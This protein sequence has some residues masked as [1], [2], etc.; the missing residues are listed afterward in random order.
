MKKATLSLV[1][2]CLALPAFCTIWVVTSPDFNFSPM[3][4]T[5][6]E[7][8]TVMFNINN[9]HNVVEVSETTWN[10]N[11]NTPLS[12]GFSLP[13]GGGMLLPED[14]TPGE[15][16]YVCQ[17]HADMAMKGRIIVEETTATEFDPYN[18]SLAIYPNPSTGHVQLFVNMPDK[19][20]NYNIYV[21]SLEG[22]EVYTSTQSAEEFTIDMD[23]SFLPKGIYIV[24]FNEK[25]GTYSKRLVLQ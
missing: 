20:G 17:P 15:H 18:P 10:N 25:T 12:G 2:A 9:I 16:F 5:I 3:T 13:F 1:F 24:R 23:L 14:L 19:T 7:G 11:Q 21:Y 22:E 4:L 6:Q 8:D